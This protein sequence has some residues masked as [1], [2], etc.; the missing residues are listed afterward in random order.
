MK[1]SKDALGELIEKYE[2]NSPNPPE[3]ILRTL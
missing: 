2:L 1:L 3:K